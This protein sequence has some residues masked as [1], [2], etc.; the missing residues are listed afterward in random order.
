MAGAHSSRGY[1]IS[2][3]GEGEQVRLDGFMAS[4]TLT[5]AQNQDSDVEVPVPN[6]LCDLGKVITLP[7]PV[8]CL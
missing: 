6:H 1:P 2:G 4:S 8:S 3:E 7:D 5:P